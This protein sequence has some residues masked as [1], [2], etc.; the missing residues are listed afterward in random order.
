ME[1]RDSRKARLRPPGRPRRCW[2]SR[3][4]LPWPVILLRSAIWVLPGA[5]GVLGVI[6]VID[7]LFPLWNPKRQALHDL[8]AR[9]QVVSLR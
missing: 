6:T 4:P 2:V 5:I 8:A 7:A 1:G 3:A 9:T